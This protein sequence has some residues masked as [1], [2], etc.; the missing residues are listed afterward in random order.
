MVM[1]NARKMLFWLWI[2]FAIVILFTLL[3]SNRSF[4]HD[5]DYYENL[6]SRERSIAHRMENKYLGRN[7]NNVLR[8]K[9][10]A[11]IDDDERIDGD[12]LI[13]DGDL[14]IDGE[15]DGDVLAIFGDIDLG[16]SAYVKGDVISVNG[17][18]WSDDDS[19]VR[20]DIVVTNIP[21]DDQDEGVTIKKREK[22]NYH[23]KSAKKESWPDDSNEVVYA[24]YNRVD[25]LTLGMQFPQRGWWANKDHH[26][27]MLGK[28]GYSFASKRWQYQLGLERWTSGD[29]RFSIGGNIYDMT[30]TQDR[31]LICDNENSLAAFFIK[32]DFRDYYNREGFSLYAGQNFGKR[33]KITGSYQDDNFRNIGKQTN[34]ALFGGKKDFRQNPLA[35]P[36]EYMQANGFD[37]PL[38]IKS[39]SAKLTLDTRNNRNRPSKGWF[40]NAFAELANE[41]FDNA[42]SF[43]RYI[44]D[45]A[46][47]FP[48][49]W[50][51][52]I[53]MH[54]RGGTSTG[55][56][57][58]MYWFDLGGISSLRGMRFKDMTGDRMVLG[59]MEYHLRA[60]DGNFLGMD[61][62]LFI[63]SGLAWFANEEMPGIA[64]AWPV[65][66][67]LQAAAD[68]TAPED[69]FDQLK[70]TSLRTNVGI[71]LASPDG[72]F[73]INFAKRVDKSGQDVIVTFRICQPF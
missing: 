44:I 43:E 8:F 53:T 56:L 64:N 28:G 51:E 25:G 12:V 29:F 15:V 18:V 26:F 32:E 35:L 71:A 57:P 58:P 55:I 30:D 67:E 59:N 66:A 10:D 34:W 37:A 46:H 22:R 21:I 1:I 63:D 40:I 69:S 54:L 68:E 49:S 3:L 48:L 7:K 52:H 50:D 31:W 9:G 11:S 73:R 19:D 4:A 20:G 60:G 41:Q 72:D 16:S 36:F 33:I 2:T 61:L 6:S 5:N 17:K 39:V 13:L 38:N 65:D 23:K 45:V 47:Y 42:Y 24:D 27:A 70:W 14:K 62:I